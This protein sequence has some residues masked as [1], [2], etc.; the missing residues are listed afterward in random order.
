MKFHELQ[1]RLSEM[2]RKQANQIADEAGVPH[3]TIAHIRKGRTANPQINTVEK[4][5]AVIGKRRK[6]GAPTQAA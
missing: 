4:L 2:T 6:A 1:A 3:T 5:I